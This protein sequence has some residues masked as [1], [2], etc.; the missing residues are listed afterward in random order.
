MMKA[1]GKLMTA[2]AWKPW[3]MAA[4]SSGSILPIP[5]AGWPPGDALD[6]DA[7][8]R[9]TT[10]YLPT[11]AIPMFPIELA[12]GPMS[13]VQGEDCCALSFGV[14]LTAAGDIEAY[15]IAPSRIRPTYRLTYEDVDEM[16]SLDI[17]AEPRAAGDRPMGHR[18]AAVAH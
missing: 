15:R 2:L 11:G 1:P 9:S 18:A 3:P 6:L 5:P 12:A 4:N 7:R 10:V 17:Q 13:L 16:V 14:I 8:R